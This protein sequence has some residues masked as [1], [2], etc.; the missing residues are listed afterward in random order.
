[1]FRA[2]MQSR[3]NISGRGSTHTIPLCTAKSSGKKK[4]KL[5]MK[6]RGQRIMQELNWWKSP[7]YVK[8]W[9]RINVFVCECLLLS[10]RITNEQIQRVCGKPKKKKKNKN[11]NRYIKRAWKIYMQNGNREKTTNEQTKKY[12]IINK[13]PIRDTRAEPCGDSS[14]IRAQRQTPNHGDVIIHEE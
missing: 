6:E 9:I 8:T 3:R 1:M 13:I 2:S 12:I 7:G 4:F 14:R 5:W 11:K 10:A